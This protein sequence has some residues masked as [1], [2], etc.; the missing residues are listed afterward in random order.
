VKGSVQRDVFFGVESRLKKS[1]LKKSFT[2]KIY[3]QNLK[4]SHDERSK[5]QFH[6]LD[7]NKIELAGR[8]QKILQTMA[9]AL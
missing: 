6:H 7:N 5:N 1:V 3:F 4:E 8:V 2:G 9:S